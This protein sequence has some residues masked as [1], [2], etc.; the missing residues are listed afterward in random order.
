MGEYYRKILGTDKMTNT[1][2][3]IILT[4]L[5]VISFLIAIAFLCACTDLIAVRIL[6]VLKTF[7]PNLTIAKL[8][9]LKGV[10]YGN[11]ILFIVFGALF[12]L[13]NF[14]KFSNVD[15][16]NTPTFTV[17]PVCEN[18]K[19]SR[20]TLVL[21]ML[22]LTISGIRFYW[23]NQKQTFHIDE[24]YG[25]S[26]VTQ[27]EYGLWS[28]KD[29]EKGRL[30]TGK[31]IKDAIF[32][33]DASIKDTV[34]DLLHLWVYNKDTAYNN[35]FIY[36]S[37]I[38]FTG[39]KSSDFKTTFIRAGLLNFIFFCIA[40]YFFYLLISELTDN[41]LTKVL[42]ITFAFLNPTTIGLSVFMRSY[43]LQETVLILFTYLF[44]FYYKNIKSDREITTKTNFIRT[45]IVCA[46]LFSTDYFSVLYLGILGLVLLY[47]SIRKKE[48]NLSLFLLCTVFTGL[49][50]TKCFY[51]NYGTGFFAGRGAEAFSEIGNSA[52]KNFTYT[53]LKLNDFVSENMF[54]L[55]V[56]IIFAAAGRFLCIRNKTENA[57]HTV[58]FACSLLFCFLVLYIS[59]LKALRYVAPVFPLLSF[60]LI[61]DTNK[62][63][64]RYAVYALQ[65]CVVLLTLKNVFPSQQNFTKIRHLND[66]DEAVL[67]AEFL[68]DE[69][70]PIVISH[71]CVYPSVLPYL[72]DNQSVYF[73]DTEEQAEE[74]CTGS[75]WYLTHVKDENGFR[76]FKEELIEKR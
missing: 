27:N 49:L 36:L 14:V 22:F 51:L 56:M 11:I 43:A 44:V 30:Y 41:K 37:R 32:F 52:L 60:S 17:H 58:I 13:L 74:I 23:L 19:M 16:E 26:I 5:S 8:A 63:G 65:L 21:L 29:F 25:I 42:L 48:Y 33:D 53:I 69:E 50:L 45:S 1:K 64:L 24:M 18:R 76:V 4:V 6:D 46:V 34:R 54:N 10:L 73:S 3:R 9:K 15:K 62:K 35:L 68:K 61:I 66:A 75:F 55:I 2:K 20:Y 59:P 31:E 72:K 12:I 39:F 57:T 40:F 28:G 70:N 38:W 47:L 7:K 67:N 71:D